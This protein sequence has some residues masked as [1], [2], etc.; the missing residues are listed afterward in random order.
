L[1]PACRSRCRVF[2]GEELENPFEVVGQNFELAASWATFSVLARNA[3]KTD[4]LE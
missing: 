4:G 1:G 3:Y 2:D